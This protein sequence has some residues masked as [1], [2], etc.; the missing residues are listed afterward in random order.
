MIDQLD[1]L[2]TFLLETLHKY[3]DLIIVSDG[4][5]IRPLP[6]FY[7]AIPAMTWGPSLYGLIRTTNPV[8]RQGDAF[9]TQIPTGSNMRFI[10]T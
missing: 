10:P 6:N 8:S 5:Q 2:L 3:R 9:L 7:R 1:I 4:P